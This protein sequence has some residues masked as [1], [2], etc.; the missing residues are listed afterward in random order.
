VE[1]E[2]KLCT[3][4]AVGKDGQIH[5][6]QALASSVFHAASLVLQR[7]SLLWWYEPTS[8]L[9]VEQDGRQWTVTQKRVKQWQS[10]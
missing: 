6:E 4:S 9:R 7:I 1:Q 3:V 10:G 8:P 5:T 2:A